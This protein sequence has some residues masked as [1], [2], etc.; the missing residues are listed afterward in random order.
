MGTN[1]DLSDNAGLEVTTVQVWGKME[2]EKKKEE[3]VN[4]RN[5]RE[6]VEQDG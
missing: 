1:V 5:E 4:E 3:E 6:D 2:R